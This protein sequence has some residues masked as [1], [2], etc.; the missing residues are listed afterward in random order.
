MEKHAMPAP[1]PLALG[2]GRW[3]RFLLRLNSLLIKLSPSLFGYQVVVRAKALPTVKSL[4]DLA[5]QTS[6]RK[7][8]LMLEEPV[9]R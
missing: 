7:V 9:A 2:N 8:R 1:F 6:E 5:G 4:L 3:S